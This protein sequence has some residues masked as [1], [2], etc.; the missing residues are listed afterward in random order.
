MMMRRRWR[1]R[2]RQKKKGLLSLPFTAIFVDV[3]FVSILF[4][5]ISSSNYWITH[6]NLLSV[7]NIP[8]FLLEEK[9]QLVSKKLRLSFHVILKYF[10]FPRSLTICDAFSDVVVNGFSQNGRF[11]KTEVLIDFGYSFLDSCSI[12]VHYFNR[13]SAFCNLSDFSVLFLEFLD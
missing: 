11:C 10:D 8:E 2:K 4:I 9:K 1:S 12:M 13:F 7:I 3:S 6:K 5:P